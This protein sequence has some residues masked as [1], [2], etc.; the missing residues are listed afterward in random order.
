MQQLKAATTKV[1][2]YNLAE[3]VA[4]IKYDELSIDDKIRMYN[5]LKIITTKYDGKRKLSKLVRVISGRLQHTL[6]THFHN[7]E[8]TYE[9]FVAAFEGEKT[10]R[11]L[12]SDARSSIPMI[13]LIG[14]NILPFSFDYY[15][16]SSSSFSGLLCN[17]TQNSAVEKVLELEHLKA[18]VFKGGV[19]TLLENMLSDA[20]K[21]VPSFDS[22]TLQKFTQSLAEKQSALATVIGKLNG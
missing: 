11:L 18:T 14:G 6:K 4:S 19:Y 22:Q 10:V 2:V 21:Q 8:G 13:K 1:E 5:A 12:G 7:G 9:Q 3:Q 17:V 20:Y 15:I 16:N